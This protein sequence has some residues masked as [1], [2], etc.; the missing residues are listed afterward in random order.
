MEENKEQVHNG[1]SINLP[2]QYEI[3]M[4]KVLAS[5]DVHSKVNAIFS[6]F[7][8]LHITVQEHVM[9]DDLRKYIKED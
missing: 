1:F 8:L 7:K 4:E 2:K 5:T 3:D 6:I 9:T